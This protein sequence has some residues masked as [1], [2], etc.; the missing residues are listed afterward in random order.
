MFY[1]QEIK[2]PWVESTGMICAEDE[3][4]IGTDHAGIIVLPET[5][6]PGTLAKDYYN[7]K[8]DMYWKWISRL[9]VRMP[10]LTMG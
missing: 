9:T 6:V 1:H 10:A 5:A 8:S 4:G 3:I 7:I 2:N